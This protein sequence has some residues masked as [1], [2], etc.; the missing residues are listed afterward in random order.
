MQ[1]LAPVPSWFIEGVATGFEGNTDKIS[2]KR[3]MQVNK[4]YT[5]G[6]IRAKTVNWDHVVADDAAFH[7]DVL[8]GE[9]Y[10]HAWSIHWFLIT[11][12]R[13]Q[14]IEYLDIISQKKSFDVDDAASRV[15]DFERVFGK[16]VG[17]L[18]SE[19]PTW[20]ENAAKKQN[21]SL[22]DPPPGQILMH[23][24]LAEVELT[25]IRTAARADVETQGRMRNLS[26]LRPMSFHITLETSSGTYAEWYFPKVDPQ[27]VMQLEKQLTTKRMKNA[28]ENKPSDSLRVRVRSVVPDSET[29]R[30]WSRGQLP[31]PVFE[32]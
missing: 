7:G 19:F 26:Q 1:R 30:A 21:V 13:K 23:S 24:N 6:A 29:G 20:L 16:P 25:A 9:A 28:P 3:P 8:A 10:A 32:G 14:Y 2:G 27:K 15:E 22:N 12:Y 5:R 11:K 4:L 18:Q 17:K 31:T